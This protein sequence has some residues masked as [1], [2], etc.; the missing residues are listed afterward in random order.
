MTCRSRSAS[1][2]QIRVNWGSPTLT[3]TPRISS[4]P[5]PNRARPKPS[6]SPAPGLSL[7][8][9]PPPLGLPL[10][11]MSDRRLEPAPGSV[12]SANRLRGDEIVAQVRH[13]QGRIQASGQVNP[14]GTPWGEPARRPSKVIGSSDRRGEIPEAR[15]K[16]RTAWSITEPAQPLSDAGVQASGPELLGASGRIADDCPEH[17]LMSATTAVAGRWAGDRDARPARGGSRLA[18]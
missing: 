7:G 9:P 13:G 3:A 6:P 11:R 15:V 1:V 18:S 14:S 5:S 17:G 16:S 4:P 8:T 2:S 12:R 10:P